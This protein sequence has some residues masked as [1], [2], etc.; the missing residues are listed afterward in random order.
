MKVYD[1][2]IEIF[3]KIFVFKNKKT[4]KHNKQKERERR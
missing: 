2:G 3:E 4:L 1:D